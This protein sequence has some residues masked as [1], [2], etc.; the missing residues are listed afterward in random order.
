MSDVI[1]TNDAAA[2]GFSSIRVKRSTR[3]RLEAIG[4]KGE[5]YE[6]VVTWLLDNAKSRKRR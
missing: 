4:R 2:E 3:Q 1:E 6:D 5:S